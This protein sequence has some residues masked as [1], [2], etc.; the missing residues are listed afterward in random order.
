MPLT[1]ITMPFGL[2]GSKLVVTSGE[3]KEVEARWGKGLR[4]INYY[5]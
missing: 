3:R 4:G 1:I 2:G 5:V